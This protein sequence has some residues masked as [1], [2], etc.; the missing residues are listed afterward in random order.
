MTHQ[1]SRM[2]KGTLREAKRVSIAAA[3]IGGQ[4]VILVPVGPWIL[5]EELVIEKM[6][7]W[8]RK[9][10]QM[11]LA[12]FESTSGKTKLY[13]SGLSVADSSRLLFLVFL[14]EDFVGHVGIA[15]TNEFEAELDNVM[16]SDQSSLPG[17]MFEA[18][19]ALLD[20]GFGA[21]GL[22]SIYLRVTS[23]NKPAL[24]LYSR[25]G[26]S[27]E[28]CLPLKVESNRGLTLHVPCGPG[29]SDAPF[30]LVVMR[31]GQN[32][33]R[34]DGSMRVVEQQNIALS[35]V[36]EDGTTKRQPGP[37]REVWR[38]QEHGTR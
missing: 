10:K 38:C 24:E 37:T 36:R 3:G 11:F 7:L 9:A 1:I 2:K 30:H 16:K 28:K 14:N 26:F 25:L 23:H 34:N 4:P 17:L 21:L 33:W 13:L 19:K 5:S 31:I 27:V 35:G 18:C 22:N 29:D 20:W 15:H 32:Q 12:Q 6:A 8:R